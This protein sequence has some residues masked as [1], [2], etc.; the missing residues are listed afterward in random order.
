MLGGLPGSPGAEGRNKENGV[1]E[2][3]AIE[4]LVDHRGRS[5]VHQHRGLG[6]GGRARVLQ[7]R[8]RPRPARA[9]RDRRAA[10]ASERGRGHATRRPGPI[11]W[12]RSRNTCS[13]SGSVAPTAARVARPTGGSSPRS[14][15]Q[16]GRHSAAFRSAR[17]EID[18]QE[19]I[20]IRPTAPQP[21]ELVKQRQVLDA[22]LPAHI[23][24]AAQRSR[25]R[26]SRARA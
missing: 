13:R 21:E 3:L 20:A 10:L 22:Q 11:R 26:S 9:R 15:G 24:A 1:Q 7:D 6:H 14:A 5:A 2:L 17:L 25:D 12:N 8:G 23:A 16:S 19:S 4:P 18:F